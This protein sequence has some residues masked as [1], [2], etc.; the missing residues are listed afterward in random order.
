MKCTV[1]L[2]YGLEEERSIL[3]MDGTLY[4]TEE[5]RTVLVVWTQ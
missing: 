4:R 2:F 3:P 5:R 1:D